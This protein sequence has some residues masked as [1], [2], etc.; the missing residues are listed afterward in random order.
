MRTVVILLVALAALAGGVVYLED[1][2]PAWYAKVRYPL[3]YEH[4]ITGHARNYDLDAALIAA[5]IYRESKFDPEARSR[6]GALGL[7]QLLPDTAKGIAVHT[8]GDAFVVDDLYNP[9]INVRYGAFYLRRLLRKYED[10]R[11]ALAAY[12][13]G[14]NRVD[15]WLRDDGEIAYAETREYVDEVLEMR[16]LYARVY[17][18]ELGLGSA[19]DDMHAVPRDRVELVGR[20]LQKRENEWRKRDTRRDSAGATRP[21]V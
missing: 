21:S 19:R 9:E 13:A 6:S 17:A 8:G 18:K 7:M 1:A 14:Q 12:N 2:K 15:E 20:A 16:E 3:A 4:V 11:L 5:V 10:E